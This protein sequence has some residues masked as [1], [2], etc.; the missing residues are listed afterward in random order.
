MRHVPRRT[1]GRDQIRALIAVLVVISVVWIVGVGVLILEV[2]DPATKLGAIGDWLGGGAFLLAI[3][4][5][6]GKFAKVLA[7][8]DQ[9]ADGAG[10]WNAL[11]DGQI[12]HYGFAV[13]VTPK[14]P[15]LLPVGREHSCRQ[16]ELSKPGFSTTVPL[17]ITFRDAGG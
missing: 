2:R 5:P 14:G 11:E 10:A 15:P 9:Q 3:L 12:D 8:F 17:P 16:A 4:A 7:R 1:S 6:L 13:K